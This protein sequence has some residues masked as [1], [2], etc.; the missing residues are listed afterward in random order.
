MVEWLP[1]YQWRRDGAAEAVAG[2]CVALMLVPQCLAYAMVAGLPANVGLYA[3]F[4]PVIVYAAL[5]TGR[6]LAVG[7]EGLLSLLTGSVLRGFAA[8]M[9][10]NTDPETLAPYASVLAFLVGLLS[11]GLGLL[12]VGFLD[13]LMSAPLLA[14]FVSAAALLIIEDQLGT[15]VG[16]SLQ[17]SGSVEKLGSFFGRLGHA[18]VLTLCVGMSCVLV[19]LAV[20]HAKAALAARYGWVRF[21]PT[22]LVA[23]CVGLLQGWSL[24]AAGYRLQLTGDIQGGFEMPGLD[25]MW[26]MWAVQ[27]LLGPALL[28][29]VVG[30]IEAMAASKKYALRYGYKVSG[31]QELLAFGV[32]NLVGGVFKA[33]P[34]FSS[35]PRTNVADA[36]GTRTQLV[37]FYASLLTLATILFLS[38]AF[39]YLPNVAIAAIVVVAA[40]RLIE[41]REFVL[42]GLLREWLD[43]AM[44]TLTLLLTFFF[45]PELGILFALFLSAFLLIKRSTMPHITILHRRPKAAD[46][47]RAF[48][49]MEADPRAARIPGTLLIR[50]NGFLSFANVQQFQNSVSRLIDIETSSGLP[51]TCFAI[52]AQ[53]IHHLD[54]QAAQHLAHL[55]ADLERRGKSLRVIQLDPDFQ[56]KVLICAHHAHFESPSSVF[57]DWSAFVLSI[58]CPTSPRPS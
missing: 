5:G 7:P 39:F 6:Q 37:G 12:R 55:A 26:H 18:Q 41:W 50:V 23:V 21:L 34:T 33:Y 53:H 14:G 42:L 48:V 52:D 11:V 57:V 32:A 31:D 22:T 56:R 15:F 46:P 9:H 4:F 36:S 40:S 2:V 43:L 30:F 24:T 58:S 25:T 27:G 38:S 51:F 13:N 28:I 54:M 44:A 35:L 3:G 16:F 8:S 10:M 20:D 1:R 29:T 19:I 47:H 45:G 17:G 49:D